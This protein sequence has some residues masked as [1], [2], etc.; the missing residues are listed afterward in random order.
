MQDQSSN[1]DNK[2]QNTTLEK[3]IQIDRVNKVVSGGKRM[4]FRAVV[5][6]GDQNGSVGI[7]LG[8]SKE[9]PVAIRKAV[10]RAKK[11]KR[12]FNV[13]NGTLPHVVVGKFGASRVIIKPARPG[14]GVI[15]GGSVRIVL[16]ALGLKNVVA[17]VLGS[18][19]SIN[20]ARAALNA[21]GLSKNLEEEV[22]LRG[23]QLPVFIN[24]NKN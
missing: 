11:V 16:E 15:A 5:I 23:K 22:R 7:G 18:S 21:L 20:C 3:V 6:S 10:E 12:S 8:K 2:N 9:V 17:K 4:A 19:N 1:Q 14:T 13:V 24:E